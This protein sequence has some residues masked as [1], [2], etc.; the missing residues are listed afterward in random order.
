MQTTQYGTAEYE[1]VT[2]EM[3]SISAKQLFHVATVTP[4]PALV[5]IGNNVGNMLSTGVQVLG[6][7][8]DNYDTDT[9]YLK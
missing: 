7:I 4:E 3:L 9:F 6:G 5:A 1:A 8:L 2:N